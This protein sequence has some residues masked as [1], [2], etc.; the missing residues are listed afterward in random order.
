MRAE[1]LEMLKEAAYRLDEALDQD[2]LTSSEFDR[3]NRLF[4][5]LDDLIDEADG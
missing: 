3:L 5:D 2:D 1:T 4:N